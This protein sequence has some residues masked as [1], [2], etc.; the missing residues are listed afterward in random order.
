MTR[1]VRAR[2]CTSRPT[3][4]RIGAG[5]FAGLVALQ[6]TGC[7]SKTTVKPE[8]AAQSVVD[9]VSRQT[10]FRPND[11]SCPSGVEAKVG[12]EFD[13]HFTGPEGKGYTAHMRITKVEGEQV[14]FDVKSRP[15]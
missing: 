1:I 15:S 9:V 7:S 13:C 5:V 6:L 4:I 8:G 2:R 3:G 11:V 14:V 12:Q 10:G